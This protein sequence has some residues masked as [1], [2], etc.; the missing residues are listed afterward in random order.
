V[1]KLLDHAR[2]EPPRR[3]GRP[4][5]FQRLPK[6]SQLEILDFVDAKRRRELRH[7]YLQLAEILIKHYGIRASVGAVRTKLK[8]LATEQRS[9]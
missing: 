6:Q 2:Q 9:S 1:N 5:W 3:A 7:S 8:A 4:D